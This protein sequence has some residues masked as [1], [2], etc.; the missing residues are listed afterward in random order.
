[1]V[2]VLF[3]INNLKYGGAERVLVNLV[4]NMDQ[5]K[6][7]ITLLTLFDEGENK[8]KLLSHINYKYVFPTTFR[9]NSY[10]L[11]MFSPSFLYN[12]FIQDEYDILVSYL[13]GIPSRII[14]A[15]SDKYVKKVAWIHTSIDSKKQLVNPVY[16]N[17]TEA[18]DAYM[19]YDS[20]VSVSKNVR[21]SFTNLTGIT[22]KC[23]VLYNT[24][25]T[26][27]I[28]ELSDQSTMIPNWNSNGYN[29]VSV[30]RL[31]K[32]KGYYRLITIMKKIIS[33]VKLE[34]DVRLHI[35]GHG[36]LRQKLEKLIQKLNLQEHVILHGYQDNPY[37]YVREADIF[38]CS[39]YREGFSTA[40]TEALILGCPVLTTE[41]SGMRELLG[42]DS[43]FG[44]ITENSDEGLYSGLSELLMNKEKLNHLRLATKKRGHDFST[45]NTVFNTEEYLLKLNEER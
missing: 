19:S 33:E 4:N 39:S 35:I 36:E 29:I 41:C 21:D 5:S 26:Q 25:D 45:E 23:V 27:K 22:E 3:F 9:A 8:K 30:G 40:V 16:R 11:K 34:V 10:I 18:I 28:I 15:C 12:R 38:V 13:E 17:Y 2:R 31:T 37:K 43:E 14:S 32:V 44:I 1:M 42:E 7:S 24:V 20:I 6:F